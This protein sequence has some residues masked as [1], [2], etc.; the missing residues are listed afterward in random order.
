MVRGCFRLPFFF[1]LGLKSS[2]TISRG[3]VSL[4]S[5]PLS[6]TK[7]TQHSHT[8]LFALPLLRMASTARQQ[9]PQTDDEWKKILTPDEFRVL[10]KKATEPPGSGEYDG[11]SP[12]TGCFVCRGCGAP[13]FPAAS[14]FKSGCGWPA[15]DMA[16]KAATPT[17]RRTHSFT[18]APS[19]PAGG[20]GLTPTNERHCVNSLSIRYQQN[21]PSPPLETETLRPE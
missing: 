1:L 10:R 6:W 8:S 16:Y 3:F 19:L 15:F 4:A 14:K 12:K 9:I 7:R 13:L 11:F 18:C 20:A 21:D 5:A 17:G 2:S